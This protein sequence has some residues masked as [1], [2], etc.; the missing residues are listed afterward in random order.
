MLGLHESKI[1]LLFVSLICFGL[2]SSA[3]AKSVLDLSLGNP[4][5]ILDYI[6]SENPVESSIP[7]TK[8]PAGVWTLGC[9]IRINSRFV[10]Y[11]EIPLAV[12]NSSCL[13]RPFCY[14][15]YGY[16]RPETQTIGN[17]LIGLEQGL[18]DFPAYMQVSF[19]MP[20]ANGRY[21]DALKVAERSDFGRAEDCC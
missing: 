8:F 6:R 19:R 1:A 17:V 5:V 3:S 16:S 9:R 2:F 12:E 11:T 13:G 20:T 15:R 7:S 14:Y 4:A 18:I 10:A 21:V